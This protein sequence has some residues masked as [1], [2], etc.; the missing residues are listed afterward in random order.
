MK[1]CFVFLLLLA[2]WLVMA[3]ARPNVLFIA[4]DDLNDWVGPLAGHPQVQTPNLDRLAAQGTTFLNAH[5]QSPLCNPSRTS[6]M[7]GLRPSST[8]IYGL[9]PWFRELDE[10]KDLVTLPQYFEQHGYRTLS[11][12]KIYH[13]GYGRGRSNQE[14]NVLGPGASVGARPPEKLVRTP[15]GNH[16]LVDWGT[17]PHR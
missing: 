14:F 16:P 11:T 12:G 2:P 8:G 15:F 5:C 6:V 17:F 4:I 1:R 9:S 13:G 7:T 3:A 10:F